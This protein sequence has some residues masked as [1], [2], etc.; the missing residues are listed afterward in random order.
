M[1]RLLEEILF[2]GPDLEDRNPVIDR[3]YVERMLSDV[4]EDRDLSRYIL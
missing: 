3:A 2:E 1:E 4:V